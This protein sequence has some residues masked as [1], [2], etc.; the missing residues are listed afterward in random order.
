MILMWVW[1]RW[2]EGVLD[3]LDE[4]TN[5]WYRHDW[6]KQKTA[7]YC[8]D[9]FNWIPWGWCFYSDDIDAKVNTGVFWVG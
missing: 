9:W 7:V 1:D 2:V 3:S 5:I 6:Q 8:D 4:N